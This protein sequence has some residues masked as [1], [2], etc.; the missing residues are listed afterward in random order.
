[1]GDSGHGKALDLNLT[2]TLGIKGLVPP[3]DIGY[4]FW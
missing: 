2:H 3:K 4:I 1:V